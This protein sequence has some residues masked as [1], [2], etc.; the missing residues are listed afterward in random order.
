MG[1]FDASAKLSADRADVRL[2]D[3]AFLAG[4][5]PLLVTFQP[6]LPSDCINYETDDP[7]QGA[8]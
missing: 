4:V 2:D 6:I 3:L 5:D 8:L 7:A 1:L